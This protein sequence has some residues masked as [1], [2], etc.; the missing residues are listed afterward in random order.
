MPILI[1]TPR[2][3][4]RELVPEDAD[5]LFEM[6][7]DAE[8]HR[9][10]HQSPIKTMQEADDAIAF[11]RKQYADNGIGRWAVMDK[12]TNEFLGWTGFKLMTEVA[13][14]HINHYDF[15]YRFKRSVWG[16]GIASESGAASLTYGLEAL[17]L[18]PVFAMTDV[19]NMVSRHILEKLGF[20][21]VEEFNYD[22]PLPWGILP[23]RLVTWYEL[24]AERYWP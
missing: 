14:G 22:G 17:K 6:D 15:G 24:P 21:F 23:D 13:N 18:K 12:T 7:S 8:V 16:K 9:Y 3:I 10:I 19:K 1:E 5:G 2:L 4:I 11:I 20:R